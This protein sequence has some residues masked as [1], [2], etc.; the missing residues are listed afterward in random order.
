MLVAQYAQP[1]DKQAAFHLYNYTYHD[2]QIT[3]LIPVA[4]DSNPHENKR[5]TKFIYH[6]DFYFIMACYT[7]LSN[8]SR[9]FVVGQLLTNATFVLR[10]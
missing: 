9:D 3:E 2:D 8:G 7:E 6:Y 10:F 4:V 5:H 1:V